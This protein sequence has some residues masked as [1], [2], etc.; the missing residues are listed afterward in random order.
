MGISDLCCIQ[1]GHV[2]NGLS[3]YLAPWNCNNGGRVAGPRIHRGHSAD[4]G[5]R[6]FLR[7]LF[8]SRHALWNEVWRVLPPALVGI[9]LGFLC[10]G[11]VPSTAFA[12][13]IGWIVLALLLLQLAQRTWGTEWIANVLSPDSV[14]HPDS[15]LT[16]RPT[17]GRQIVATSLGALTGI[18]TMLA[19]A[20][21]PVMTVYLL[22]VGLAKY[23]FV[24]TSAWI[25]C[26]INLSKLPFSYALGVINW[27]TLGFNLS[28][29]PAVALGAVF[30]KQL[31]KLIPQLWFEWFLL[32]SAFIAAIR[33]IWR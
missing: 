2:K 6:R 3:W 17:L 16:V 9:F 14:N 33:L 15:E 18:T 8:F 10:F 5:L 12:P 23:E 1:P 25:F 27:H 22:A 13:V 30:G 21:G 29:F 4:V 11:L 28:M 7:S 19:N 24:G 20:A 32:L 31:L 26:I